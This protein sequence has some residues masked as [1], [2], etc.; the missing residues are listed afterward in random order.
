MGRCGRH[1]GA[2]RQYIRSKVPR[3]R[4]TPQLHHCF[5]HAIDRLGGQHKATPKLV[6]QLMDVKGLTISHVKSHLQ[7]YRSMRSDY[8]RQVTSSTHERRQSF[9]DNHGFDGCVVPIEESCSH[10]I[11][12]NPFPPKRHG[13][14]ETRVSN[15]CSFDD[16]KQ[17]MDARKRIKQ[18]NGDY[19]WDQT[20]NY[21]HSLGQPLA[22]SLPHDLYSLNAFRSYSLATKVE[23]EDPKRAHEQDAKL[24]ER[25][26]R[27]QEEDDGGGGGCELS[28]SLSLS[29]QYHN[30][31][32]TSETRSSEAFSSYLRSNYKDCWGSS[33]TSTF[34]SSSSSS[35]VTRRSAINLDLS[36]A[37]CG[38]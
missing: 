34:S 20:I 35:S 19:V 25:N 4:W 11:D 22:L 16:Y 13:I 33:S 23:V 27:R 5:L 29:L 31:S 17:T 18:D 2:V 7:M 38:N 12:N 32:S 36:I 3:L 9:D 10:L 6:L 8:G 26:I 15:T 14:C 37:L 1:N 30:T 28:L 21:S 24:I